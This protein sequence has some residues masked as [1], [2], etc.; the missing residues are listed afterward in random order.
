MEGCEDL[1]FG[2]VLWV[3]ILGGMEFGVRKVGIL[4]WFGGLGIWVGKVVRGGVGGWIF[5]LGY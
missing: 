1:D 2:L 3:K 5:E 4:A